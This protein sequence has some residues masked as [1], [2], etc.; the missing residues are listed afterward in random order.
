MEKFILLHY[1]SC[2]QNKKRNLLQNR[3]ITVVR[4]LGHVLSFVEGKPKQ[5]RT[6]FSRIFQSGSETHLVR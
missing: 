3:A 6:M 2:K 5:C 4:E 1:A